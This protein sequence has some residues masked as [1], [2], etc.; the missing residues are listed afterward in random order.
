MES[1]RRRGY[2]AFGY[3]L[4]GGLIVL[5]AQGFFTEARGDRRNMRE[6]KKK[7]SGWSRGVGV[8]C[9]YCHVKQGR[10]FDYEADTTM[11]GVGHYC[12][13]AF[14][15][16]LELKGG[17]ELE[18]RHCHDGAPLILPERTEEDRDRDAIKGD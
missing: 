16:Q 4:L 18:C 11:R 3:A 12:E 7:M 9:E 13:E 6:W 1:E 14:V 10:K 5:V 15:D 17:G 8:K 2:H